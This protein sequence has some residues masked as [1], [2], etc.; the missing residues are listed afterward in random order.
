M[1][2]FFVYDAFAKAEQETQKATKFSLTLFEHNV[3]L[4]C[5]FINAYA[6]YLTT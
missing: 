2:S 3:I 6:W 1:S 5:I 4:F